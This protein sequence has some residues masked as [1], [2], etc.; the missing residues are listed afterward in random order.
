MHSSGYP[1]L[2]SSKT[3]IKRASA[4][5]C[6]SARNCNV[7]QLR[8]SRGYSLLR[9]KQIYH[10]RCA[11]TSVAI[12]PRI[13]ISWNRVTKQ[14]HTDNTE[15]FAAA[16]GDISMNISRGLCT[17]SQP[18]MDFQY[19]TSVWSVSHFTA[20]LIRSCSHNIEF[21]FD[22]YLTETLF[23]HSKRWPISS[24]RLRPAFLPSSSSTVRHLLPR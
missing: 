11:I 21:P 20:N 10:C 3:A 5:A 8:G 17:G 9:R 6:T 1:C 16:V 18:S 2:S 4:T 24:L 12:N 13:L 7:Q 14:V 19:N 23:Q 15:I 22:A